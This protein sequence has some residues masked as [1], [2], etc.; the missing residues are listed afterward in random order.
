[1]AYPSLA[2][3]IDEV[4]TLAS[5]GCPKHQLLPPRSRNFFAGQS[6]GPD[7]C[8]PVQG[9]FS[10]SLRCSPFIRAVALLSCLCVSCA[11]L[12]ASP[13]LSSVAEETGSELATAPGITGARGGAHR[14]PRSAQLRRAHALS[15]LAPLPRA[16]LVVWPPAG[17]SC[18]PAQSAPRP[19]FRR[20]QAKTEQNKT[21]KQ[22]KTST[23][24]S[25]KVDPELGE[26][27]LA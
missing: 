14:E 17:H 5:P 4:G 21:P 16:H 3:C 18:L 26:G 1:M 24:R 10:R 19:E 9:L 15:T 8:P 7:L 12:V 20:F 27:G 11:V 6:R 25:Q 22:T 23:R 13:S 2:V